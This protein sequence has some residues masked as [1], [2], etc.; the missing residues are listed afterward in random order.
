MNYNKFICPIPTHAPINKRAKLD[1]GTHCNYKCDFCY[2]KDKLN[3][4]TDYSII[5]ERIYLLKKLGAE[6]ID[7]SGGE[8]SIHKDWFKILEVCNNEFKHV[9]CLSNGSKFKDKEFLKKSKEFGLK[10]ILFSLHG[11][12]AKLHDEIVGRKGAFDDI[13]Q[14]IKNA[15]ELGLIV[16]LNCTVTEKNIW[17]MQEYKDLVNSIN[18]K[19]LN[20]LPLNYW[21]SAKTQKPIDYNIIADGIKKALN[22]I[23]YDIEVNIRYVPFCYFRG[24]EKH[25]VDTYQHIHDLK[26]WNI[27]FYD[28]KPDGDIDSYFATAKEKINYTYYKDKKCFNCSLFH[29]CDGIEKENKYFKPIPYKG[30]KITDVLYYR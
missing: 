23:Y 11:S 15:K 13:I 16:R 5:L 22:L 4:V 3:E 12:N 24:Y 1:T 19:Q 14:A 18:P 8:S 29:I 17:Y 28:Y 20:F 27:R 2:Y 21:D 26:D 30:E 25:I 9:S 6:E 7:L 10:E